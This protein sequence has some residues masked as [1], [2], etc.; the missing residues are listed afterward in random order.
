MKNLTLTHYL[1]LGLFVTLFLLLRQC[2]ETKYT[3]EEVDQLKKYAKELKDNVTSDTTYLVI[4]GTP[5][6]IH[7]TVP[8]WYPKLVYRNVLLSH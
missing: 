1:M 2:G 6:T 3:L 7:D 8:R 5:D 4:K